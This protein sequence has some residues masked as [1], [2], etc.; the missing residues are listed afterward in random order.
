VRILRST[1][2]IP[3]TWMSTKYTRHNFFV[4]TFIWAFLFEMAD[5]SRQKSLLATLDISDVGWQS[6]RD[7]SFH[8]LFNAI[9]PAS[10][11]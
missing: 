6:L 11:P 3:P 1:L 9:D 8:V 2:P 5:L 10:H 7:S 4:N